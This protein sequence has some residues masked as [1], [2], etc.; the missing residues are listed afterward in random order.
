METSANGPPNIFIALNARRVFHTYVISGMFAI[1]DDWMAADS[2]VC[3]DFN[4]FL[5]GE[6]KAFSYSPSFFSSSFVNQYKLGK[7]NSPELIAV[8]TF[9]QLKAI[10]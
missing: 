8:Q 2:G 3:V 1:V 5:L 9:V 6:R 7:T 4:A 10:V